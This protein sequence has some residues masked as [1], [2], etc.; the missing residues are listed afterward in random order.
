MKHPVVVIG[1][2]PVGL[3]AV[4]R[5]LERGETPL[6][7]EAG[8]EAAAS[9]RQWGHVRM[10]SSWGMNMDLSAMKLLQVQGWTAPEADG[11][12]T[13]AELVSRYLEP[14]AKVPA[15]AKCIRYGHR[16]VSVSRLGCDKLKRI[17]REAQPFELH[18]QQASGDHQRVLARAVI[19]A[20]GTWDTPSPGGHSGVP[21]SGEAHNPR[22][23]YGIPDVRGSQ[24]QRYAHRDVLVLGGG[25][26]AINVLLDLAALGEGSSAQITWITRGPTP[27]VQGSGSSVEALLPERASALTQLT[28]LVK[29]GRI[30]AVSHFALEEVGQLGKAGRLML[31]GLR[32]GRHSVLEGD[33]VVVCTGFRPDLTLLRELHVDL[34]PW[35][36]ATAGVGRLIRQAVDKGQ[37][38]PE[39]YGAETLAH[40]EQNLFTVGMKSHGRAPN[41]F[42]FY[43]YEQVRSVAAWLAGDLEAANRIDLQ[44]PE[45]AV[46]GGCGDGACCG[47]VGGASACGGGGGGGSGCCGT[48]AAGG[49]GCGSGGGCS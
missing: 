5:L 47:S 16:V 32:E 21:A 43:G 6:V 23:A 24:A 34:D 2:G 36:E 35:L 33:E 25:H 40:P 18:V 11:F 4:S 26:S 28:A 7:F 17:G 44:L 41:F 45:G 8:S 12:P 19:D 13:G 9:V 49:G 10:F 39:P 3:A 1:A 37:A 46:C 29:R 15:I 42:L 27:A 20:S 30:K 22:V 31:R 48:G 38:I 14:L